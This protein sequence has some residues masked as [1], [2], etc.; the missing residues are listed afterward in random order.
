[1][2]KHF[3]KYKWL[4]G[5]RFW[6]NQKGRKRAGVRSWWIP[7]L[8]GNGSVRSKEP[9]Q[10]SF[11]ISY[12]QRQVCDPWSGTLY[13]N[14][15][16][17]LPNMPPNWCYLEVCV[18]PLCILR[19]KRD[20]FDLFFLHPQPLSLLLSKWR[21]CNGVVG[22]AV[23]SPDISSP[24]TLHLPCGA[25]RLRIP[26]NLCNYFHVHLCFKTTQLL[27]RWWIY[28]LYAFFLGQTFFFF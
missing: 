12:C 23:Y 25:N 27:V 14:S 18:W 11:Y 10:G 6:G 22:T 15:Y 8:S 19:G 5:L 21:E 4:Q 16:V 7:K 17:P 9:Q 2:W 1:M 20:Y 26:N 3:V 28:I 24:I 13:V